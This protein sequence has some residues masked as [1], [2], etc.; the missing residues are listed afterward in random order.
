MYDVTHP[1]TSTFDANLHAFF[2]VLSIL[3]MYIDSILFYWMKNKTNKTGKTNLKSNKIQQ[4]IMGTNSC[5]QDQK[6]CK[7]IV[8]DK[9]GFFQMVSVKVSYI[10]AAS[11]RNVGNG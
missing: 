11:L 10:R 1:L 9:F 5:Y 4:T 7:C 6:L 2:S 8:F 3:L